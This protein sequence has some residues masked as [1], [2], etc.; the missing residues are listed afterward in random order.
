MLWFVLGFVVLLFIYMYIQNRLPQVSSHIVTIPHLH[1]KLKGKKIVHL[2]DIHLRSRSNK[3]FIE[4]V[5]T[6]VREQEPDMIVFTGDLVQAGLEDFTDVSIRKFC[7]G[8]SSI[9]PTYIVTG[10]HDIASG[11]FEDLAYIL[12]T[13]DVQLL[14]DEPKWITFDED[15]AGIVLMGLA[16][17]REMITAPKPRLRH[18]ELTEGM[19]E[20]PKLLL[21]H[22]PEF[23]EEYLDDK[24]KAPDL[25]L[26]GH[27]H[28]GQIIFPFLGGL[29]APSQGRFPKY[30]FGIFSSEIDP[31]KRLIVSRGLG[32]STFPLRINNRPEIICITL[33]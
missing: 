33:N 29:Y 7:E 21:A 1:K 22:H 14:V 18:I 13:S 8:L 26:S 20:Q 23:F 9:A 25:I 24:T 31:S 30:D 16:E 5:I 17:R 28:G 10:N 12:Q 11:K 27:T 19:S 3:S 32:N 2:T 4:H 15:S 6:K